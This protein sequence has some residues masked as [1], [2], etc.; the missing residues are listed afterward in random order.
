LFDHA[1]KI[2]VDI[3]VVGH[4]DVIED[5]L[6]IERV[7]RG[8]IWFQEGIGPVKVPREASELAQPGWSASVTLARVG[9]SW[10]LV[11][12][13][14]VYPCRSWRAGAVSP[15]PILTDDKAALTCTLLGTRPC[16]RRAAPLPGRRNRR[17]SSRR[18][19]DG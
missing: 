3:D 1:A 16:A 5:Y 17:D 4:D 11:E 12:V 10:H 9:G 13:G 18:T 15:Q 2:D 7:E 8:A 19:G 6:L 14:N